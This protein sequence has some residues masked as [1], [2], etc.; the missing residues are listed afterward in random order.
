MHILLPSIHTLNRSVD[1][2]I[3]KNVYWQ[4]RFFRKNLFPFNFQHLHH[5]KSSNLQTVVCRF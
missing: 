3:Q 5:S 2:D 1:P 4:I